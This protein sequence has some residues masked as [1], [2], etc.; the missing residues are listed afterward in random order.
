MYNCISATASYP[1]NYDAV[2]LPYMKYPTMPAI[3]INRMGCDSIPITFFMC[4][5]VLSVHCGRIVKRHTMA[6]INQLRQSIKLAGVIRH[7]AAAAINPNTDIRNVCIVFW[8]Y[9]LCWNL[10]FS[11]KYILHNAN[12]ITRLGNTMANVAMALPS[13]LPVVV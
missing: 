5:F 6:N 1:N 9:V 12:I 4:L 8:K 10:V 2:A 7:S 11:R 3:T 13:T